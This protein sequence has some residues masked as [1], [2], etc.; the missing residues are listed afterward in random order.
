MNWQFFRS[1]GGLVCLLRKGGPLSLSGINPEVLQ[2]RKVSCQSSKIANSWIEL[3]LTLILKVAA[4]FASMRQCSHHNS[5][6]LF[7]SK[8]SAQVTCA[9]EN[10]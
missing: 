4:G 1:K 6:L 8:K 7:Q 10:L 3:S 5:Q 2:K 9:T